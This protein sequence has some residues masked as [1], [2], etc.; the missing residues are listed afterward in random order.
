MTEPVKPKPVQTKSVREEFK[1]K[2]MFKI[3]KV[4]ENGVELEQ[5]S[6][7]ISFGLPKAKAILEN[8]E[9]LKKFVAENDK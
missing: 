9:E 2:P 6:F 3:V 4:D 7:V 8:L 1:G 5:Y